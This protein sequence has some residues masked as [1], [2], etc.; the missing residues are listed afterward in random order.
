MDLGARPAYAVQGDADVLEGGCRLN[1]W[2]GV[3][4]VESDGTHVSAGR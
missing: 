3:G 1:E 2:A 4:R